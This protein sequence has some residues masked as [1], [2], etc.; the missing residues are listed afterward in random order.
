MP[1]DTQRKVEIPEV[2]RQHTTSIVLSTFEDSKTKQEGV[3]VT[4]TPMDKNIG[5][6]GAGENGISIED[7]SLDLPQNP[8]SEKAWTFLNENVS[9]AN[10]YYDLKQKVDEIQYSIN[11]AERREQD[12]A[13]LELD[14]VALIN[15]REAALAAIVNPEKPRVL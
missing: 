11:E 9:R 4:F 3:N 5:V 10:T 15:S 6:F 13:Q 7:F 8:N 2:V 1:Q 14:K 12:T